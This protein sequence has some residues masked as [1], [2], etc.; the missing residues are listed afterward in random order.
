MER[1]G[2]EGKGKGKEN[3]K[4]KGKKLRYFGNGKMI[5]STHFMGNVFSK[6]VFL[7][8]NPFL[9]A[10]NLHMTSNKKAPPAEPGT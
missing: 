1:K 9:Q 7:T 4:E 5:G 8:M 3:E 6:C 2:R 10:K